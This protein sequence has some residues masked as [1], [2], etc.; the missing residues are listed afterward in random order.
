MLGFYYLCVTLWTTSDKNIKK[1]KKKY[2]LQRTK[3]R[4]YQRKEKKRKENQ[5]KFKHYNNFIIAKS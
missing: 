2:Q 5:T 3:I 1:Y 4:P